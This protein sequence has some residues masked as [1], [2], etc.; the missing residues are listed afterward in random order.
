M[1]KNKVYQIIKVAKLYYEAKLGQE[2]IAK[3]EGIS[4]ATVSR[5]LQKGIDKGFIKVYIDYQMESVSRLENKLKQCFGLK[6]VFVC[7]VTIN[8]EDIVLRDV[9][10]TLADRLERY[11]QN[12]SVV[13]VS[14]GN[15]MNTLASEIQKM[16]VTNVNVVQLNGGVPKH[17]IST[18]ATR[19]VDTLAA[20]CDGE[21]YLCPVPAIVDSKSISDVLKND[22]QVRNVLH[23]AEQSETIIFSIGAL[24]KQ[25]ILFQAGYFKEDEYNQLFLKKAVG[26]ICSRFFNIYGEIVDEELDQRVVGMSFEE[27]KKKKYRIAVVSGENKVDATLG[28]LLGDFP[29]VLYIDEKTA[30]KV[31]VK[32]ETLKLKRTL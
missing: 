6:D 27:I 4:K 17:T 19:I 26:D 18:G 22:S 8:M 16:S 10:K 28:A 15:T 32:Y 30:E 5:L 13:G 9:C 21:G 12:N 2:D 20:A 7:P 24:T 3:M 23:L 29:N 14:W 11:I 1:D 31:L 25:S